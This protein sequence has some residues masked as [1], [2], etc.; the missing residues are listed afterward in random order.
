[1]YCNMPHVPAT[2]HAANWDILMNDDIYL[3]P[4]GSWDFASD[5]SWLE[6][7]WKGDDYQVIDGKDYVI[8]PEGDVILKATGELL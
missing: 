2:E 6:S 4:D 5:Y 1:M 8:T 7:S 3:W